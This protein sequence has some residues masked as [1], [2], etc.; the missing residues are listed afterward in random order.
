MRAPWHDVALAASATMCAGIVLIVATRCHDDPDVCTAS[1]NGTTLSW[2]LDDDWRVT[3]AAVLIGC[4]A[5]VHLALL[6]VVWTWRERR[7]ALVKGIRVAW[8]TGYAAAVAVA[9]FTVSEHRTLHYVSAF[10]MF[11]AMIGGAALVLW[12]QR[13][14]HAW[15]GVQSTHFALIV[16]CIAA[17]VASQNGWYE[18]AGIALITLYFNWLS[19]GNHWVEELELGVKPETHIK[20]IAAAYV[21]KNR[22]RG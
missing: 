10:T 2:L 18:I 17:Y 14:Q 6:H 7:N 20:R 12:W 9:I 16:F 3:F 19:L 22:T 5:L 1:D 13:G 11:A 8:S 15:I 4:C 21:A